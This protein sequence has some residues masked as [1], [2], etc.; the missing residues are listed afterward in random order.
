MK[1]AWETMPDYDMFR[2]CAFAII[3]NLCSVFTAFIE[4]ELMQRLFKKERMGKWLR[5]WEKEGRRASTIW[6]LFALE[7]WYDTHFLNH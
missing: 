2:P 4:G 5:G 7:L 1:F 6:T 3:Y